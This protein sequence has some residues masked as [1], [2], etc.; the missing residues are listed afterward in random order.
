MGPTEDVDKRRVAAEDWEEKSGEARIE[1]MVMRNVGCSRAY[2][3][4]PTGGFL[5]SEI[6]RQQYCRI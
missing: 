1:S 2:V 3:R 5:I 6:R 4:R